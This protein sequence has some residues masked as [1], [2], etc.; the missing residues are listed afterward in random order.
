MKK[1]V[2]ARDIALDVLLQVE[3]HQAYSNLALNQALHQSG[4]ED[5]DKR[6]AT[7]LIYG[8]IGRLNTLDWIGNRLV[9]KGLRSLEP[10]V[11]QLVRMSLYQ[12]RY[13]DKIPERAAVHEAVQIAKRRGHQGISSLVNGVLRSY[14]RRRGEFQLSA[15]PAS[16]KEKALLLSHPEWMVK[17]MEQAYGPEET[18]RALQSNHLPPKVS[19][20][21]NTL[22]LDR[23]AFTEQWNQTGL[24]EAIVS[25]LAPDGVIIER[26]GNPAYTS[27]FREGLC[28]IQDESS[29]LVS[30]ILNPQPGMRVLDVCAAPGGKTTHLA[31]LMQN[32]GSIVACDI[33]EH[34]LELIRANAE[35]LGITIIAE[36]QA[37]G[38]QVGAYWPADSFDA[39][40]LDAPCS[41]LGVIRRKPD[42]KWSKEARAIDSLVQL[43]RELLEEVAPLLKPGGVLVYSTCT[44]EPRENK[45]QVLAFT[46]RHPEFEL[47]PE[48]GKSLTP[49]VKERAIVEE[50]WLQLL[51]HHFGSDGFFMSRLKKKG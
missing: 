46:E 50:G 22:K 10:W 16:L 15:Q 37:D 24:G 9:K 39:I 40:L 11:R 7:E 38:R 18:E 8:T 25:P 14:L 4:L 5:R 33:H 26:G 45:E 51:P 44:W 31:E 13:L 19:V 27:F 36:R 48:M 20:R 21:V 6:L 35:R 28:T 43:Q 30:R 29:M 41:G 23:A 17:R 34:K 47:D 1:T 42:I 32:R 2:S 12:L 3:Q 49:E